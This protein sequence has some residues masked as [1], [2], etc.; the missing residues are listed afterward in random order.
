MGQYDP[1][2]AY[3]RLKERRVLVAIAVVVDQTAAGGL[4]PAQDSAFQRPFSKNSTV[5]RAYRKLF[6]N[7]YW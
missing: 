6:G 7:D 1:K 3:L 5:R 2:D 4:G